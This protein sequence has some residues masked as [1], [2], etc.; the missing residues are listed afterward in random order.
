MRHLLQLL[1]KHNSNKNATIDDVLHGI[2]T[3]NI[4]SEW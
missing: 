2:D 1:A 3:G 4:H